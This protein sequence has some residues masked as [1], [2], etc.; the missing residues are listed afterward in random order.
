MFDLSY[1][2]FL[3][4]SQKAVQ[5]AIERGADPLDLDTFIKSS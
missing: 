1:D 2:Q 4:L 5:A 3:E